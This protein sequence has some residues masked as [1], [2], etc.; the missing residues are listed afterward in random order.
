M[1]PQ[2]KQ[3]IDQIR[4]G[5]VP[6]G[7]KKTKVGIVPAEWEEVRLGDAF[8]ERTENNY[9][10]A[11]LLSITGNKGVV[12]RTEIE[13]KDNSS[14]DKSSY[15][16]ICA[17]DIGYNTMRMWQGVSAL[18]SLEGIVSPAYTVL[19]P[20]CNV[21]AK[22]YSYVFKLQNMI[23]VFYRNSQG[24]VD[25]T[26]SL[27][28]EWFKMIQVSSPS[29]PEQMKI[30]EVLETQDKVI[31]LYEKKIEEMKKLK[32]AFLQ[33]IFPKSGATVPEWRFPGFT[34]AWEQRKLSE[35]LAVSNEK[36]KDN[37]YSRNDVFSVSGD[38]GVV[39]QI[40]FQGRSFAG[41]ALDNYGIVETGDVVYTKSPL[42]S[43]PYGIIKAN[44]IKPGIVSVLYAVYRPLAN[45]N[46]DFVQTYFEQD[47]RLNNYL[48]P[49]ISKGAKN[50][51]NVSD[52]AALNGDV[53]FP[54]VDEQKLISSLFMRLD[55]LIT[56]HQ[57]L[58]DEEKQKKKT[59][60]QLLLAGIVRV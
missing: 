51:I 19:I 53:V 52:E 2:I 5:E 49:L 57:R 37:M 31:A 9:S 34:D 13:G 1:T 36:N 15:K 24:L 33:K 47:A 32:K 4:R 38:Y 14:V 50:T 21:S 43:A 3:R 10:N 44:K 20:Q 18:S 60:M 11:E 59:L 6:E 26:R 54:G 55:N 30:A 35:Y 16:H 41:A 48:R 39:N 46:P 28:Y 45:C 42:N 58:C 23:N 29:L 25:D 7:Y 27:K 8:A 12:R 17:G 40:E 56:L 22:Y